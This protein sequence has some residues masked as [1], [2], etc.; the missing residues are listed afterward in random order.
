MITTERES[1][2]WARLPL[3]VNY[4]TVEDIT[5]RHVACINGDPDTRPEPSDWEDLTLIE[6][7]DVALGRGILELAVLVGP[8]DGERAATLEHDG[9]GVYQI[10]TALATTDEYKVQR[11]GVWEVV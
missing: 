8:S 9:P 2:V 4:G 3:T 10:W 1:T 5:T 11:V 7:G 6:P